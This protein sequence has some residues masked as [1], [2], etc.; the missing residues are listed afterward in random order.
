VSDRVGSRSIII[1]AIAAAVL[2]TPLYLLRFIHPAKAD[3]PPVIAPANFHAPVPTA[4]PTPYIQAAAQKLQL[5][6]PSPTPTA[7]PH[8]QTSPCQPC[9]E[10]VD[11]YLAAIAAPFPQNNRNT[12][13]VPQ[14]ANV[15]TSPAFSVSRVP[16]FPNNLSGGYELAR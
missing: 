13:E 4:A 16:V 11:D 12:Y 2:L 6:L 15:P 10:N 8:A 9:R 7:T 5:P 1:V 14:V 3:A